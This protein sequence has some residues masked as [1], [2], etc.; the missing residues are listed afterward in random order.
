LTKLSDHA[1]LHSIFRIITIFVFIQVANSIS[2]NKRLDDLEVMVTRLERHSHSLEQQITLLT[3]D[4][5]ELKETIINDKMQLE[6]VGNV[7]KELKE[8]C[9]THTSK[10]RECFLVPQ[11]HFYK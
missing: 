9:S 10:T 7:L 5:D 1:L 11:L 3:A 2:D 4:K 8:D 6:Q